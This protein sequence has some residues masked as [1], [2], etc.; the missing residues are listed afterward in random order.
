MY[1]CAFVCIYVEEEEEEEGL[2][3]SSSDIYDATA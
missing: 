2:A 1:I 3:W